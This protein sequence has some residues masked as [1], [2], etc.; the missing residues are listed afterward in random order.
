M[1]AFQSRLLRRA[2]EICGGYNAL[3]VRLGIN[4]NRLRYWLDGSARLPEQV[5]L[6]VAD[7]VL[8]DDI[9]RADQDRRGSPRM[10][11]TGKEPDRHAGQS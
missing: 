8:E 5:F 10:P 9:A 4:E 1:L 11:P 7:I 6:D 3:C 2:A